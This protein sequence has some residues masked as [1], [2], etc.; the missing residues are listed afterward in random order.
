MLA[1]QTAGHAG[2][3]PLPRESSLLPLSH[4]SNSP[5]LQILTSL[6]VLFSY[7]LSSTSLWYFHNAIIYPAAVSP[8][9]VLKWLGY[10]SF[11]FSILKVFQTQN[12]SGCVWRDGSV[13]QVFA[14]QVPEFDPQSSHKT[15]AWW[16]VLISQNWTGRGRGRDRKI[17]DPCWLA[18]LAETPSFRFNERFCLM[19][20]NWGWPLASTYEHTH[21]HTHIQ[22]HIQM[23]IEQ[24]K[25]MLCLNWVVD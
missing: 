18:S 12:K 8:I 24:T 20:N 17:P 6:R 21:V 11:F 25:K 19:N 9:A 7:K 5:L 13:S 16:H 22:A 1:M 10:S 4:S 15:W 14:V 3:S 2:S 23:L